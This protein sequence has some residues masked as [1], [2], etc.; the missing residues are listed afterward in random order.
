MKK[1][2]SN[3]QEKKKPNPGTILNMYVI[4]LA[5]L[6]ALL[7]TMKIVL[8][9]IKKGLK[10]SSEGA[11]SN[12]LLPWYQKKKWVR[13]V[14]QASLCSRVTSSYRLHSYSHSSQIPF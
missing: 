1:Y 6:E 12:I 9:S 4:S 11:E 7:F 3:E 10:C 2:L 13:Q 8:F 14:L 5:G